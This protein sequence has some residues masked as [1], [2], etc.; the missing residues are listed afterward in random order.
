ME[1]T[2]PLLS[3]LTQSSG[4]LFASAS[5][6]ASNCNSVLEQANNK[7]GAITQLFKQDDS[8]SDDNEG[9]KESIFIPSLFVYPSLQEE[10][11]RQSEKEKLIN[12]PVIVSSNV[13]SSSNAL[14]EL[15]KQSVIR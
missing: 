1:Q 11:C 9:N 3:P 10:Q 15:T 8:N 12:L 4:L 14:K 7:E 5:S 6:V 2:P 13:N